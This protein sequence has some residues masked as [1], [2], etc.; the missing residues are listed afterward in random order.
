MRH[1]VQ[2]Y[3][4]NPASMEVEI[5]QYAKELLHIGEVEKAWQVLL[6]DESI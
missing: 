4:I 2:Y 3:S 5:H 1:I 6:V